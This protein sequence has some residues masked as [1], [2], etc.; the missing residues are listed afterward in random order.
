[1]NENEFISKAV[2]KFGPR[3]DYSNMG[4]KDQY[5]KVR[6]VCQE[7]GIFYQSPRMHLNGHGC[8]RCGIDVMAVKRKHT[9]ED[10]IYS[11]KKI[12]GDK[13]NY[14]LSVYKGARDKITIICLK[15]GIF[16][17]GVSSHLRGSGCPKCAGY[18]NP[19]KR[20]IY[21][22]ST[23]SVFIKKAR[24]VYGDE[25][26]YSQVDYKKS[27]IKIK[28]ICKKHGIFEQLPNN[29]LRGMKCTKCANEQNGI[30]KMIS[31]E[32]FI[33]RARLVHGDKYKYG[34][35]YIN[36]H[37]KMEIFC[38]E[39][40]SFM[41]TP[42]AHLAER[43][44][45]RCNESRGERRIALFLKS[46]N[47][48]YERQKKFDGCKNVRNLPFDFYLSDYNTII[49]HDGRQHSCPSEYFGGTPAFE[50]LKKLD[51]I[52][53][54]YCRENNIKLIRIPYNQRDYEI[55]DLFKKELGIVGDSIQADIQDSDWKTIWDTVHPYLTIEKFSSVDNLK[56]VTG[57]LYGRLHRILREWIDSGLLMKIEKNG[58]RK[59]SLY[60]LPTDPKSAALYFD[61]KHSPV[62][63]LKIEDKNGTHIFQK[64]DLSTY[65]S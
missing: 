33:R 43:G 42:G 60:C 61:A 24:K 55:K 13:Y 18:T 15:H 26:D 64:N 9:T 37:V 39:H 52:K 59:T 11:A 14:S 17:Q 57:I 5:T 29:H 22:Q 8:T 53:E 16:E 21:N 12:H 2:R 54:D 19:I 50:Y 25:Y 4:Y 47:I 46:N 40:G 7:H 34:D 45:P 51:T 38:P 30:N 49:E 27:N 28:I 10:F 48:S 62:E 20:P 58:S 32:E 23:T 63:V 56:Q 31:R 35:D 6:L 44:C 41:Q 3:F 36:F 65:A 1:M